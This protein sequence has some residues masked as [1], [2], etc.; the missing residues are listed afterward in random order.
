MFNVYCII[1]HRNCIS[2]QRPLTKG[3]QN[4]I[5]FAC[6]LPLLRSNARIGF[7]K[8]CPYVF[9][10]DISVEFVSKQNRLSYKNGDHFKNLSSKWKSGVGRPGILF[11]CT[12]GVTLFR[13][14]LNYLFKLRKSWCKLLIN[15]RSLL[16]LRVI[17]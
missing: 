14:S 11:L 10:Y 1:P 16:Y 15:I 5:S 13:F 4:K 17:S 9:G 7:A 2:E 8:L 12:G 3:E 6:I